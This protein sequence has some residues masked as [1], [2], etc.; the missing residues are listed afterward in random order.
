MSVA[1]MLAAVTAAVMAVVWEMVSND[2]YVW[3][4]LAV[5]L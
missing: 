3:E 2:S 5:S 1:T 4:S